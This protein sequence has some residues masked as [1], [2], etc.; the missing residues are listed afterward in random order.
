[1]PWTCPQCGGKTD[2]GFNICW[3]CRAPRPDSDPGAEVANVDLLITTT[4]SFSTHNNDHYFGPVFGET[5]YGANVLRD[6][7]A[8]VTD[9][10][11]G[12]SDE[13]ETL[14]VRGRNTAMS[15]MASRAARM[16][17]NAV[18]GMHF[19]Y[20]TVGNSMLMICCV[21]T[22]VTASPVIDKPVTDKPVTNAPATGNSDE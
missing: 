8:A 12:R 5:I 1:M 16:G 10:I 20:S 7:F 19:D 17:A 18:V 22:A 4:P 9:V 15:E 13:Y 11:G 2:L 14:L 3:T 21:G 6:F